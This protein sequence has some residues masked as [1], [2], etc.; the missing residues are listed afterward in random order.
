[1]ALV[2]HRMSQQFDLVLSILNY[3]FAVVFNLEAILK[4]GAMG[5]T[6]FESYWNV[7]DCFIVVGT[8]IGITMHIFNLGGNISAATS[9]VRGFRIMRIFRLVKASQH[10][11][12]I[13]DTLLNILPQITNIM[14]LMVLLMF[15]YA[16][17]GINLFS[18]VMPQEHVNEKN[19][20]Q[21][22][23]NAMVL[24]MR[25]STGEDWNLI[26]YE[27]ANDKGYEGIDCV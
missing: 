19:N 18:T 8:D 17:L 2:H 15:I 16:A 7:F 25:C 26:M 6:Y 22:F 3:F 4:L 1:M 5:C 10:I 14:A 13:I 9:V 23:G 12:I 21:T 11:K 20:F 24:L 27:L